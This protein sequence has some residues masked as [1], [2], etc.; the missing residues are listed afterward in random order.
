MRHLSVFTQFTEEGQAIYSLLMFSDAFTAEDPGGAAATDRTDGSSQFD[1]FDYG[2]WF[3]YE[4]SDVAILAA[5]EDSSLAQGETRD[6]FVSYGFRTESESLPSGSAK[7]EGT[8]QAGWWDAEGD[9]DT[10]LLNRWL[11]G[12]LSL[13]ANF[14]D[15]TISG[16]VD[17]VVIPSWG[18]DSGE[19][20]AVGSISI[21]AAMIDQAEFTAG[22][23]GE[24]DDM[25]AAAN[26]TLRGFTGT[27]IG[28][29]YGPAAEE[30]GGVLSG[31]RPAE[32]FDAGSGISLVALA[33]C[34]LILRRRRSLKPHG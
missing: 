18:T 33:L 19:E 8:M 22:W 29:F 30:A 34:S 28:E 26:R 13:E 27:L 9:P 12:D 31:L 23:T 24:H 16:R 20:V 1:Y 3:H 17:D 4:G 11:Q 2:Y 14:D 5:T 7:Y 10:N 32:G 15:G 6:S 25:N 21:G